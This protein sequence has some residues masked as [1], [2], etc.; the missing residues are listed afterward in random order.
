M[1]PIPRRGG[2]GGRGLSQDFRYNNDK[3]MIIGILLLRI[4][5]AIEYTCLFLSLLLLS[6]VV[7]LFLSN[8]MIVIF[9]I[10]DCLFH[11]LFYGPSQA[12]IKTYL[13]SILGN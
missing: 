8:I 1:G 7:L 2:G 9:S 10:V 6:L 4:T 12:T 5:V 3:I 13:S 11:H